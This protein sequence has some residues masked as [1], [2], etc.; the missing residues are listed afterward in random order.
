MRPNGSHYSPSEPRVSS[1]RLAADGSRDCARTP[2][3]KLASLR[4]YALGTWRAG[5]VTLS[6]ALLVGFMLT[7]GGNIVRAGL[8]EDAA[9]A[10]QH[11]DYATALRL[12]RPLAEQ[13]HARAQITLGTI[14]K[15]KSGGWLWLEG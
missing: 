12:S 15:S 1:R 2:A 14:M 6:R 11:G 5:R 10:Y 13:G 7:V 4:S 9:A 8:L 3:P